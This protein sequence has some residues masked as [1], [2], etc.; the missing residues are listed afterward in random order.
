MD[1]IGDL[2]HVGHVVADQDHRQAAVAE[3]PDQLQDLAGLPDAESR[4]RLV[5]DDDLA[6]ERRGPGDG[7]G[8]ALAAGQRLDRLR[9]LLERP[10][11]QLLEMTSR[12]GAHLAVVEHPEEPAEGA[13]PADLAAQEHVAGDVERRDDGQR[14]VDGLDPGRACVLRPAEDDRSTL[15]QDL[16]GVRD[17]R[18]RQALDQRRLARAVVADDREDLARIEIEVRPVQA[19]DAPERLDQS[20]GLDD[21]RPAD[22]AGLDGNGHGVH[23]R[24]LRIH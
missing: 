19:D 18:A 2:E 13:R 5:E 24:T 15:D 11:P 21:R 7:D 3:V 14:L 1:A 9:D 17:H 8:L 6:A 23:A 20:V 16:A 10:D 12:L 4:R 22:N